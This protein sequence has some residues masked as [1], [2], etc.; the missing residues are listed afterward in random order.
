MRRSWFRRRRQALVTGA[1]LLVGGLAIIQA[2]P[3]DIVQRWRER[4]FDVLGITFVRQPHSDQVVVVDI[5]RATLASHGPWPW[6]HDSLAKL[7]EVIAAG[8]PAVIGLDMVLTK[9]DPP[10]GGNPAEAGLAEALRRAPVVLGVVL[11]PTG[12][13]PKLDGPPLITTGTINAPEIMSTSGLGLPPRVLLEAAH[14]VGVITLPAPEGQPVREVPLLAVAGSGVFGGMAVEALR[15]AQGDLTLIAS[16]TPA[17]RLKIGPITVPLGP[18]A[19]M[20]LHATDAEHR[21]V[22]TISAAALEADPALAQRFR[23]KI[24]FLGVSAPEAGGSLRATAA[25]GFMPSVQIQADA[26]EQ[27][28]DGSF[29]TPMPGEAGFERGGAIVLSIV[30]IAAGALLAPAWA[31]LVVGTLLLVW[32]GGAAALFVGCGWLIDPLAPPILAG[33]AFQGTTLAGYA[34]TRRERRAIESRFAQHLAPAVVRRIVENPDR[35]RLEGEQREVTALFTDIEGFTALTE[36]ASSRELV[37]M[38]NRYIDLASSIVIR[39]GG[40]VDKIVGDAVHAFFNVPLDLRDHASRA[41]EC[42]LTIISATEEL[43][44]DPGFARSGFGRTRIGIETGPAVVGDFG[45]SGKLD[46]TAHGKAINAAAKLE[47][48]NKLFGSSIAVGPG[49]VRQCPGIVFRPLG[50]IEPF[51]GFSQFSPAS[52]GRLQPAATSRST[53][54]HFMPHRMLRRLRGSCSQNWPEGIPRTLY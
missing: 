2:S 43:R 51:A 24:V 53:K 28:L 39:H 52:R 35:L 36:R 30:A 14:G 47:A 29:L 45:G 46:Y 26:T 7:I 48:A 17:A 8:S 3:M 6:P 1:L 54:K 23:G 16:G 27:L 13:D 49:A 15:V 9:R 5:D 18:A 42:A 34:A 22:R 37:T 4:A 40:M 41:V 25:D 19:T 10:P 44:C 12:A 32:A 33:V 50:T 20:R 21:S 11:D 38:L 31:T